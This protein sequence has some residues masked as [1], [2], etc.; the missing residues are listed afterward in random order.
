MKFNKA[1]TLLTVLALSV[2]STGVATTH[3]ED[4]TNPGT[5]SSIP[6]NKTTAQIEL[7]TQDPVDPDK[8][9]TIQLV[10]APTINFGTNALTGANKTY[11][12]EEIDSPIKVINPGF[13]SGW[14]VYAKASAFQTTDKAKTLTGA[15]LSFDSG[16]VENKDTDTAVNNP[17]LDNNKGVTTNSITLGDANGLI[18]SAT[19]GTGVGTYTATYGLD[20]IHLTVP[21]S[22]TAAAYT[23]DI[24]WELTNTP[25]TTPGE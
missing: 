3:A 23:A 25:S 7:T 8:P 4:V 20:K 1:I 22:A 2:L 10:S 14:N 9:N 21:S 17:D 24:T 16:L 11:N 5:S 6:E 13:T 12:A 18:F 15:A 19:S